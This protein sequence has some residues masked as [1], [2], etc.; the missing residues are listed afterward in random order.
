LFSVFGIGKKREGRFCAGEKRG[1]GLNR[2]NDLLGRMT[3]ESHQTE[4]SEG[5]KGIL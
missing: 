5:G 2:P 3:E 1:R 4:W